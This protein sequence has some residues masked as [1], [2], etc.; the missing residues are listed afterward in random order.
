MIKNFK[1]KGL[2]KLFLTGSK[3]GI[4]ATHAKKLRLILG[5]LNVS[6]EPR[7]M[8][9]PGLFLHELKGNRKDVWSIRVSGNW[10][11]TFKFYGPDVTIVNYEDYH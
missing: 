2:E 8:N 4:Q 1:H 5:R 6:T 7:D 3:A 11:V 9:L 10:R